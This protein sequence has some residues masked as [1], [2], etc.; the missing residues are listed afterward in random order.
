MTYTAVKYLDIGI[1]VGPISLVELVLGDNRGNQIILPYA[2]WREFIQRRMDVEHIL[3]TTGIAAAMV[4]Q[5]L[6]IE[7][8]KIRHADI[9]KVRLQNSCLYMKPSTLMF[10]YEIEHCVEHMYFGLC[11]NMHN[12]SEKFKQFATILQQNCVTK[13]CDAIRILNEAA[14]KNSL[15]DCELLA[16]ALDNIMYHA[17]QDN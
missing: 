6:V 11:E 3:Q 16:Y 10:L 5:D 13:K 1:S 7:L 4:I 9:V 2:T 12:V 17:S 14:N 8:N 15:V